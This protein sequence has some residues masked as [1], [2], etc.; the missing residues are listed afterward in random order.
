MKKAI[1][2]GGIVTK[3]DNGVLKIC[4]VRIPIPTESYVFPKGHLKSS[5]TNE[6]A[7][8][9]EMHEETGLSNLKIEKYLGVVTRNSVEDDREKV[10]KTIHLFLMSTDNYEHGEAE[11]NYNWLSIEEALQKLHFKKERKFLKQNAKLIS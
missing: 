3:I 6:A 1:S 9:R 11:E 7:A 10:V 4:L 8:L 2:S 5:E